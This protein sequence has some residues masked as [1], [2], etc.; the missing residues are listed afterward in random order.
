MD[1]IVEAAFGIPSALFSLLMLVVLGYWLLVLSGR[2][3]V[4]ALGGDT[5]A[6]GP[7]SQPSRTGGILAGL[8]LGGVPVTVALSLLVT[9][10]WAVS[11][12]GRALLD[13]RGSNVGRQP[14]PTALL[15]LVALFVG[16]LA[17]RL[18]LV[19]LRA[20]FEGEQPMSRRELLGQ[21]CVT[22]TARVDRYFGQAAVTARN[23]SEVLIQVRQ[24]GDEPLVAGSSALIF[25]YDSDGKF[26]WV[27]PYDP[28]R[29][30]SGRRAR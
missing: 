18:V 1:E 23:G 26:F 22:C 2:L 30:R 10:A 13:V 16:W 7:S 5:G 17:T 20:A 27:A 25:D 21:V 28:D 24:G 12:V 15:A 8:G 29:D 9:L 11:V 4:D 3:G 19:P 14:V 6:A